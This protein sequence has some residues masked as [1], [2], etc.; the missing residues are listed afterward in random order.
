MEQV[1]NRKVLIVGATGSIGKQAAK[2]LAGS[3]ANLF[4]SGRN[5]LKINDIADD[6]KI[7]ASRVFH[8]DITDARAVSAMAGNIHAQV[9]AID[10][11]LIVSGI[12]ILQPVENLSLSSFEQTIKTNLFGPFLLV[13][14]FLPAM[15]LHKKGLIINIPGVLG[16]IPMAGAAAY[17]ASKFGLTGMMQ[18]IREELKRTEIRITNLYLGG[19]DTAFWD[20]IDLR[21]QKYKMILAEEAARAIWFLCQQPSSGVV[22]EMVL[23]PFNH[24][25]I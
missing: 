14:H 7:P 18:S 11:L 5:M 10:I 19:T 8:C 15:K 25:A 23:Q 4:V 3:G 9:A 1:K 21:V 6:L 17:S 20:T 24:Q 22:S 12:G 2:L 16:K 13:K